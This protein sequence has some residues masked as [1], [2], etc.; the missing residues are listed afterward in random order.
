MTPDRPRSPESVRDTYDRIAEHFAVTRNAPWQEV[1]TF[2]EDVGAGG[3][4][5]DVGSGNGRHVSLLAEHVD[6]V[7]GLDISSELLAE[8]SDRLSGESHGLELLQGDAASIPVSRD[9]VDVALS[10][11]TLHHLRDRRTRV[12]GLRE[13]GCVLAPTGTAL[14][15]VWS[16]THDR[17]DADPSET[18]G[19]DTTVDWTLPNGET[20]PRFYHIYSPAEFRADLRRAAV[21]V[22]D[23]Y[24]SSGNC[25]AEIRP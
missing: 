14:V 9:Q 11:A 23:S 17:F 7:L 8:A 10:I 15:S 18:D 6:R 2:L 3:L 21:T 16:T 12:E 4:G 20:V 19:F 24:V 13:L 5:L 1:E 25:Y 22:E